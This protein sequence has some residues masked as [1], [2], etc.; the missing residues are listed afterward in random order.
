MLQIAHTRGKLYVPT[1][2]RYVTRH[3]RHKNSRQLYASNEKKEYA[4]VVERLRAG[5]LLETKHCRAVYPAGIPY[6]FVLT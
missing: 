3:F 1:I 2:A 4:M 6:A 5:P